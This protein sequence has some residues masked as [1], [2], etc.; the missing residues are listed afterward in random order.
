MR[1]TKD[2]GR[3]GMAIVLALAA[4]KLAAHLLIAS[5]YGIFRDELYFLACGEH[6]DWGYVDQPPLIAAIAWF[7][8]HVLGESLFALRLLPA[9]AGAGKIVLAGLLARALGGGRYAQGLAAL[10]VLVAPIYLGIDHLLTMNA[11]EPLFWMG[12]ALC[13]IRWIQ[14]GNER[15]W[16]G[17]G[18]LMGL[19]LLNKQTTLSFGF[20]VAAGLLL[21]PARRAFAK[22]GIW[23]GGALA[24][25]IALPNVVWMARH[26]FPML[27]LL[28]NIRR[29]GRDVTLAPLAF[30]GE[31]AL[32]LLPLTAPIWIAGIG[33]FL[34]AR[35]GRPY[36][37]LGWTWLVFEATLVVTHGRTYYAAPIFPLYLAAGGVAFE[38]LLSDRSRAVAFLKPAF[39]AL[40]A[41]G[42]IVFAPMFLP[43]L[44][45]EAFIR[46]SARLGL[47]PPKLENHAMG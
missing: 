7:A 1:R 47:S 4:V 23:I 18:V 33:W 26:G 44:S 2:P 3:G 39:A 30:L 27:E 11:F 34:F 29:S 24:A 16:L 17:F 36:R 25:L 10:A 31:Q 12:G 35:D 37:C 14:T 6:L 15:L 40:V 8:R 19:G 41:V 28:E 38:R 42:G 9:L 5:R 22:P 46:Y 21:S 20:A 13:V 32:F 45:E 43:V